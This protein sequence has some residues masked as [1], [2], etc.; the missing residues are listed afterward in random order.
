[1][2]GEDDGLLLYTGPLATLQPGDSEDYMAIGNGFL[3][4]LLCPWGSSQM[5]V[6]DH[7]IVNNLIEQKTR[8][9]SLVMKKKENI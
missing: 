1:M 8:L 2:T 6:N 5:L 3:P 7:V 9:L 4:L